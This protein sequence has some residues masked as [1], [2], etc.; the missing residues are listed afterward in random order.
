MCVVL[1]DDDRA[2]TPCVDILDIFFL[3][4]IPLCERKESE[5]NLIG[6]ELLS[7]VQ[8]LGEEERTLLI[9]HLEDVL[10]SAGIIDIVI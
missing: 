5:I 4:L 2:Q 6:T 3:I 7:A 1:R 9:E 10:V 8:N